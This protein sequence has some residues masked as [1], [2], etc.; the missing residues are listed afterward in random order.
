MDPFN[1]AAGDDEKDG[2]K[3]DDAS[4]SSKKHRSDEAAEGAKGKSSAQTGGSESL[5]LST[6]IE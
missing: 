3:G 6:N 1:T 4:Q 5:L 2:D